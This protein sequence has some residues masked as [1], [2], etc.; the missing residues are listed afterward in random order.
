MV[1]IDLKGTNKININIK[2][3]LDIN[4]LTRQTIDFDLT[5][6]SDEY[7]DGTAISGDD[8]IWF[9][10]T[11]DLGLK[12]L[13]DNSKLL[14]DNVKYIQDINLEIFPNINWVEQIDDYTIISMENVI[15]TGEF[16]LSQNSYKFNYLPQDDYNF[17]FGNGIDIEA[18][19]K[20]LRGFYKYEL[21]P[22]DEWFKTDMNL[23]G[24]K[25]VDFHGFIHFPERYK[26]SSNGLEFQDLHNLYLEAINRYSTLIDGGGHTK[27]KGK[28]YQG[29][30]FDNDYEMV[31]YKSSNI[32]EL[33][34]SY[35][36]MLSVPFHKVEGKRVLDLGCNEGFLCYQSIIH[37][38]TEAI[39]VDLQQLDIDL[40][41]D[42]NEKIFKF[43]NVKFIT[44]DAVEYVKNINE[45]FGLIILSSVLHQIYKNMEGSKEFLEN[46]KRN[47]D[48]MFYETPV[49]HPLMDI[50]LS[51]IQGILEE[52]FPTVRLQY[53]YDAYSSGYR[54][55]FIC[56]S[57][58]GK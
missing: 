56:Y 32:I 39:G 37:G 1:S 47:T 20:C 21:Y 5:L 12:I 15:E 7:V 50:S 51:R 6:N 41:N 19:E 18:R 34:D 40:A 3:N 13:K 24:G 23:I 17:I 45:K 42:L 8:A 4:N 55:I 48:Y 54:A 11:E 28:V 25:I 52:T 16:Q 43:D 33:Y 35:L 30:I 58:H 31:G 53:V 49:N 46:I 22:E 26:F 36:K 57:Q 44:V 29:F 14:L 38:A 10:L 9:P 2:S 27:W